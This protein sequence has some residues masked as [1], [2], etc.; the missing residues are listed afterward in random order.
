[1]DI[2]RYLE[3]N[4]LSQEEFAQKMG[5]T[6]GAVWQWINWGVSAERAVAIEK[7]TRG[8]ITRQDLRPDLFLRERVA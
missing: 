1:M 8:A 2:Q 4:K 3:K 6:Q 7:K 5:V